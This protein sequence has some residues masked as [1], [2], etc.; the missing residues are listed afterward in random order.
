MAAAAGQPMRAPLACRVGRG[1]AFSFT[2]G[3][4]V[5]IVNDALEESP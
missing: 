5:Y 4:Y 2:I 1:L 3:P